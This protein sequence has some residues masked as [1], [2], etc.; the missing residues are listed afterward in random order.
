MTVSRVNYKRRGLNK[1]LGITY[2]TIVLMLCKMLIRSRLAEIHV[3]LSVLL[4]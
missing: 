2:L 3:T 4:K 1:N